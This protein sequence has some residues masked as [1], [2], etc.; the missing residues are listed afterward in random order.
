MLMQ[1][2]WY[3]G[4]SLAHGNALSNAKAKENKLPGSE[5][6]K[7]KSANDQET[8]CLIIH[9]PFI[10]VTVTYG[11]LDL[12]LDFH[13]SFTASQLALVHTFFASS[14]S[15]VRLHVESSFLRQQTTNAD[16]RMLKKN[17]TGM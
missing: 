2:P 10:H 16:K 12:Y 13:S 6:G 3:I 7:Y 14:F 17:K 1:W 11:H 8:K 5:R 9:P 4:I 15:H